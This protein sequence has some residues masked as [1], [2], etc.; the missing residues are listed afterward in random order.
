MRAVRCEACGAKAMT[1]AAQCPA[2]SHQFKLRDGFG[3][4]LPLAY[5]STCDSYYPE[6]IG[7]CRWCG[8]KAERAPIAPK[9]LRG[10]GAAALVAMVVTALLLRN[11]GSADSAK[12][13]T[14]TA[15]SRS[16]AAPVDTAITS[17]MATIAD[18]AS[19]RTTVG[20]ADSLG[21]DSSLARAISQA[22]IDTPIPP[23]S[24]QA[25]S[26]TT[27]PTGTAPTTNAPTNA[28]TIVPTSVPTASSAS[29]SR[30]SA[31]WVSSVSRHWVV[32]RA[33]ASR[34]ARPI[35]SIG[36]NSHVQLG[37]SRGTWR[38]IRAKGLSGWVEEGSSFVVVAAR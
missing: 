2:C 14:K 25:I 13:R 38:R 34:R 27:V 28:P 31:P 23:T 17:T 26:P 8:T 33:D 3:A 37:E 36:P 1:A 24:V 29:K 15:K 9:V 4:L 6:S 12:P 7:Q 22:A 20:S 21:P 19:P 32:V 10:V 16:A 11:D 5:C 18:S 35:A 30:R